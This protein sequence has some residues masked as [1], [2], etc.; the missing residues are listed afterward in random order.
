MS[1]SYTNLFTT[2]EVVEVVVRVGSGAE[3]KKLEKENPGAM[4]FPNGEI[5]GELLRFIIDSD[6]R[7][8]RS[9]V[10]GGDRYIGL[11]TWDDAKRI[12][13]WLEEQGAK[14]SMAVLF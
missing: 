14:R 13:E 3:R 12:E 9:I 8:W 7:P 5:V 11:F 2:A 6:I 1:E 4:V 10:S